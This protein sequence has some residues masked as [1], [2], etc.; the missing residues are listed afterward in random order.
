MAALGYGAQ[1][2]GVKSLGTRK[3]GLVGE[4]GNLGL[5]IQ[6]GRGPRG[7]LHKT[8]W[9]EYR[10]CLKKYSVMTVGLGRLFEGLV[11]VK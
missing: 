10:T 7:S 8:R 9:L 6:R 3:S 5:V 4:V 1:E 11:I 2:D